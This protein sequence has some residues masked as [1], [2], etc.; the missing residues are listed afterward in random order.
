MVSGGYLNDS[1]GINYENIAKDRGKSIKGVMNPKESEDSEN[2]LPVDENAFQRGLVETAFAQ[3]VSGGEGA[4]AGR[5]AGE[6]GGAQYPGGLQDVG[7]LGSGKP[8]AGSSGL[9]VHSEPI[10][11]KA[12]NPDSDVVDDALRATRAPTTGRA[13]V[14]SGVKGKSRYMRGSRQKLVAGGSSVSRPSGDRKTAMYELSMARAFSVAAAKTDDVGDAGNYMM[15]DT[16]GLIFDGGRQPG[17]KGS[18]AG[19]AGGSGAS[20]SCDADC[21]QLQEDARLM[22]ENLSKCT[23]ATEAHEN[24]QT[25]AAGKMQDASE[26]ARRTAERCLDKAKRKDDM[27]RNLTRCVRRIWR[28]R[29]EY[30]RA[31]AEWQNAKRELDQKA[32]VARM[33]CEESNRHAAAIG[34]GCTALRDGQNTAVL[35]NCDEHANNIRRMCP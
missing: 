30:N 1:Y 22:E 27:W 25:D 18:I 32:G 33:H 26:D 12:V 24:A 3:A 17:S 9:L 16:A 31:K 19:G 23:E 2:A 14:S 34:E 10:A 7:G 11:E 5:G 20:V 8:T 13:K 21:E 4:Q 15:K 6:Y 35:F 28:C 29:A